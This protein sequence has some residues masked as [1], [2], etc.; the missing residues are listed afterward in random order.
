MQRSLSAAEQ[1][2]TTDS[3]EAEELAKAIAQSLATQPPPKRHSVAPD[4]LAAA[5]A[6]SLKVHAEEEAS[7]AAEASA[8][9]EVTQLSVDEQYDPLLEAVLRESRMGAARGRRAIWRSRRRCRRP[10]R[11]PASSTRCDRPSEGEA[12]EG[13]KQ[14]T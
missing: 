6:Q 10:G 13:R 8:I 7:R 12:H 3:A 1:A 9:E 14:R 11:R 2:A 5:I 4:E